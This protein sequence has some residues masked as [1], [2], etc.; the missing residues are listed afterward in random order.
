MCTEQQDLSKCK[1][2]YLRIRRIGNSNHV[3]ASWTQ[4]LNDVFASKFT[5]RSSKGEQL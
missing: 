2:C 4:A 1:I 3:L 5:L